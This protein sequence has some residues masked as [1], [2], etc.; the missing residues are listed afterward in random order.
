[1]VSPPSVKTFLADVFGVQEF[2]KHHTLIKFSS[3]RFFCSKPIILKNSFPTPLSS[4]SIFL[5]GR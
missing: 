5:L 1:V 4:Q 3:M 2:F